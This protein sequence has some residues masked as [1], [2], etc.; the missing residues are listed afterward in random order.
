[1]S[2]TYKDN[3]KE[4]LSALKKATENGLKA[5][6]M[7][8]ERYAKENETAID[9]GYLRNSITYAISGKSANA[10]KYASND[11]NKQGSYSGTAPQDDDKAVYI[12]TNVE[13]APYIELGAGGREALHFLKRA[14]E[15]HSEEYKELM[16]ESLKNAK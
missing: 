6:G 13:Y 1:M 12:G 11:G 7:T 8:A 3:S 9:T 5:I 15:E 10:S 4:V 2:Y 16:A 14:A